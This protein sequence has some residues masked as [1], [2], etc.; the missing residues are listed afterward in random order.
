MRGYVIPGLVTL[1]IY[2]L[3]KGNFNDNGSASSISQSDS[4][5]RV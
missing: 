4:I 3:R 2:L 1:C 5:V